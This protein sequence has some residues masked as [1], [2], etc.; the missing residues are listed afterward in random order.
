MADNVTVA[1]SRNDIFEKWFYFEKIAQD[2]AKPNYSYIV[3]Y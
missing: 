3:I 1:N 2:G